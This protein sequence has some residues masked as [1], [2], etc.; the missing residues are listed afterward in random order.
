MKFNTVKDYN[1][2][3]KTKEASKPK[4]KAEPKAKAP[5]KK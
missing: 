4:P 3:L 2:W 1:D 5:A